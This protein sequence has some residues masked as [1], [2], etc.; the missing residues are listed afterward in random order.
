MGRSKCCTV[1]ETQFRNRARLEPIIQR[2]AD[3]H[4]STIQEFNFS[5]TNHVSTESWTILQI[6]SYTVKKKLL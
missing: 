5:Y 3:V 1:S 6:Q 2:R 4:M